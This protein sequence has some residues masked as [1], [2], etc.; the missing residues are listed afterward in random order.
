MN[1]L[2]LGA[3]AAA[4]LIAAWFAPDQDGGVVGPAAATTREPAHVARTEATA[5]PPLAAPAPIAAATIALQIQPRI[6]DEE[7]G[8]L[9]AKQGWGQAQQAPLKRLPAE[10]PQSSQQQTGAAAGAPP[11]PIQFIGRFTDDGQT[12]YF[13]QI[14]GRDVVARPGDKIDESYTFDS[15][16]NGKLN[17]TY[18]PMHQQQSLAVG[19][20]N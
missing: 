5:A 11:L 10:A 15:A 20:T 9:F 8:N 16:S 14:D 1:K 2:V 12:A 4:T 3:A 17:F 7:L 13:L 6:A 18:L 19:D